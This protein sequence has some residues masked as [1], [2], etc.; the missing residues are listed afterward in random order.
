MSVPDDFI[1]GAGPHLVEASA[2]TGKTTWMVTTA[3]RLLLRDPQLSA[4]VERPERLLAVTFTRAA[5]AELKERLREQLHRVQRVAE[6][7]QAKPHEQWIEPMLKAGRTEMRQRLD[8]LLLSLDRLTVTTIHGF[9]MGVLEEFAFECGVPVGLRFLEDLSGYLED[10]VADEWRTLTWEAG[11]ASATLFNAKKPFSPADL[12][13]G[14]KTVRMAIGAERPQRVNRV[15]LRDAASAALEELASAF[16]IAHLR[17]YLG[18]VKFNKGGPRED[19]LDALELAVSESRRTGAPIPEE[20]LATWS[21]ENALKTT[22]KKPADNAARIA[23]EPFH[24]KCS[25]AFAASKRAYNLLRQDATLGVVERMERAMAHDRVAGFD[26]MIAMVERAVTHP[27]HGAR[28]RRVLSERFDAVLVDEFQDTDWAQWRIFSQTFADRPLIM[29]GDPKQSIY[30]FRGADI[31][32]YREAYAH[33]S[34]RGG[35]VHSLATNYRSDR[36][37]VRATELLFTQNPQ[38][39]ALPA[40]TLRFERVTANRETRTLLDEAAR[41]LVITNL[42][43]RSI[44]DGEPAII[45]MVAREIA[46]LL[47]S[48]DVQVAADP[49]RRVQARDIAILV[50]EHKLAPRLIRALRKVGVPAIAGATGDIAESATWRDLLQVIAAIEDP[51]DSRIVRRALATPFGGRSARV[52]AELSDDSHEWRSVVERLT[53]ARREWMA[54]GAVTALMKLAASWRAIANLA[55]RSDGERRLTDLRHISTLFQRAEAEGHRTPALIQQW[56]RRYASDRTTDPESRQLHLESDRDAV[57]ISTMHAAK[58]LEWPIVFCPF[59]WKGREDKLDVPR[60]ARFADGSRRLVFEPERVEDEVPG[61]GSLAESLRLTYVALTRAKWRT[62]VHYC[63]GKYPGAIQHLL[64]GRDGTTDRALAAEHP[65][66]VAI[67]VAGAKGPTV[68][69]EAVSPA[70]LEA[71]NVTLAKGQTQS[72]T[73]SSYTRITSGLKHQ[74]ASLDADDEVDVLDESELQA[75]EPGTS[76]FLPGGAHTGDALHLL[77]EE[78]DFTQAADRDQVASLVADILDR[79][80]LPHPLASDEARR[81]AAAFV[82]AMVDRTLATPI[83]GA[84]FAL[85]EV[86]RERT[87]REWRFNIPMQDLSAGAIAQCFREHGAEWLANTYA[88]Q[89]ARAPRSA[90]DGILTGSVD[91]VA[92]HAGQWWIVDWKSN[93]LGA[94]AAAYTASVCQ[95]TMMREHFVLQ[96]H[97]YAVALHRFLK[98]RLRDRYEYAR[99]FGGVGYAFLRGLGMGAPAWFGDKPSEQLITALDATIGGVRS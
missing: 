6:G 88:P 75:D 25:K 60:V 73:V 92:Q 91:L 82:H 3:V 90:I 67:E 65:D 53:E 76:A 20:I 28:L 56:A 99:D 89:L 48:P 33:A 9:C 80:G 78:L 66:L 49:P 41:P 93:T 74:D 21:A 4:H 51:A 42:G 45:A 38:P 44:E 16:D 58:G 64:N 34:A 69:P 94:N 12:E 72:W 61:D 70:P 32:A 54:R 22:P 7:E 50:H 2:G 8:A 55:A 87:F 39:F 62:Y 37:L 35:R 18:Q 10:A 97:V 77:F 40:D 30:A 15:E 95:R 57:I 52:I 24:A 23:A 85:S 71:R 46:R 84:S 98:S 17:Q 36:H 29:V 26:D 1:K 79:F 47:Q 31:T 43:D 81:N 11:P 63:S 13:K 5:T 83:P 68:E 59:L 14:A 27:L 19:S 86:P 96:Y